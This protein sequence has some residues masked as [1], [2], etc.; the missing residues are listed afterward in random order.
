MSSGMARPT[1]KPDTRQ[2]TLLRGLTRHA[3]RLKGDDARFT[4]LMAEAR[5]EG[6]PIERIARSAGVTVKTVYNRL[7]RIA[8]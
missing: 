8:R 2:A 3:E 7:G 1:F 4:L 5:D 6:V